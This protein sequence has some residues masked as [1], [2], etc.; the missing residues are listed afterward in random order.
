MFSACYLH[1]DI[2]TV[3]IASVNYVLQK[4]VFFR[5]CFLTYLLLLYLLL[6]GSIVI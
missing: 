3:Y 6:P 2:I 1:G 4:K 5:R